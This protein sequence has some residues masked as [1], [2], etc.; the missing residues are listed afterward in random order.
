MSGSAVVLSSHG[1]VEN[2]DDLTAFVTNVRRGRPPPPELITELRHRY[3]AIGGQSPLNAVN[4]EVARKLS[5]AL[6]VPVRLANRLWKP[7]VKDVL[8]GLAAEGVA[9]VAIVP[10]A[11]HSAGIYGQDARKGAE[12]TALT[13]ACAEDWGQHP[14]LNAAFAKRIDKS[15][16]GLDP[17]RTTVLMTAHSLPKA[18]VAQGDAYEREVRAAA[19][20]VAAKLSA[21]TVHTSV[22]FQS[23]GFG[24]GEWLGPDL[25]TALSEAQAAGF[26]T[27]VVA[28][29]GFLAD[30]VEILY[31]L[32][33]EAAKLAAD[34]G[35]R[36]VRAASLNADDDF[37]AVL[38]DVA[39]PL[40]AAPPA[41]SAPSA[42]SA[43]P[44]R[45][46]GHG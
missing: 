36:L 39:R 6:G 26:T 3:E 23:Q 42:P 21:R 32:D 25:P 20:A 41:S 1:T 9:H 10:L 19:A 38:A 15:L 29:I 24:G 45:P 27:V 44:A 4:A 12:G 22:A 40:L 7:Y 37:V 35:L 17:A 46:A 43:P 18:V 31:D 8:A 34:R 33:I 5:A 16:E 13:L 11:Q 2:L 30:H 14:A 28:P